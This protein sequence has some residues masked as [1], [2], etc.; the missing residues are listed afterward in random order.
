M[1]RRID[2]QRGISRPLFTTVTR[3][4]KICA[5]I[6]LAIAIAAAGAI[7]I[8]PRLL[9]LDNY[10][11]RIL[12]LAQKTLNRQVSYESSSFSLQFGPA[13]TFRKLVIKDKNG[14][15]SLLEADRFTFSLALLPLLHNEVRL[16]NL[17]LERPQLWLERNAVGKINIADFFT[18]E[19]GKHKVHL[20]ALKI[21]NGKVS[22]TD[23]FGSSEAKTVAL[24]D[25]DLSVRDPNRGEN[26]AIKLTSSLVANGSRARL[27]I[28]G[29]AALP[30]DG[31]PLS[32][33]AIDLA[34]TAK[35]L[36]V[37]RFWP[38]YGRY[39]PIASLGGELELDGTYKGTIR[40]FTGTGRLQFNNLRLD[41]P[42]VFPATFSSGKVTLSYQMELTEQ[43][44]TARTIDLCLDGLRIKGN[45]S[46]TDI[47]SAD[48]RISARASTSPFRFEECS[49]YIP[50]R[51]IPVA[52][53]DF[54][55]QH[56]SEGVFRVD[57]VR[58]DGRLSNLRQMGRGDNY[59]ALFVR[60]RVDQGLM[61]VGPGIPTISDISGTLELTGKDFELRGMRGRFGSSPFTLDGKVADFSLDNPTRYPFTMTMEPAWAEVAW[62]IRQE[63]PGQATFTGRSKLSLTGAGSAD[64]YRLTGV[65]DLTGADYRYQQLVHKPAGLSNRL[66]FNAHLDTEAAI[67]SDVHYELPDLRVIANATYH[68]SDGYRPPL[69]FTA[70]TNQFAVKPNLPIFPIMQ[71]YQPAGTLQ[72]T[73]SGRGNPANADSLGLLGAVTLT[74]VSIR[75]LAQLPQLSGVDG[76]IHFTGTTLETEQLT[77]RL[78]N[79][80]LTITGRLDG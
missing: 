76:T 61:T 48:P 58:L 54:I 47:H 2:G 24:E 39:L 10:R 9:D 57:E 52:T 32:A 41:Y 49:K 16:R 3:F 4:R 67:I 38:F 55:Q 17:E 80:P 23:L 79:S 63:N 71:H 43:N 5:G 28:A 50:Y 15:T 78:G 65:W 11:P 45:C 40:E 34:F 64:D 56:I 75:P 68:Y 13:F 6:L 26:A 69:A 44:L 19:H 36:D 46:V 22:F 73:I 62:L 53:A 21:S 27:N 14:E 37:N 74:N 8:L 70:T 66:S 33:A 72:A 7:V 31:K 35:S 30:A 29:T 25:I 77:G 20:K 18:G 42:R 1:F 12:S 51:I 59:K 60:S